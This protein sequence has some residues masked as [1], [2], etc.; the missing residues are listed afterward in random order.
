MELI[1]SLS[2]SVWTNSAEL[3]AV[4]RGVVIE[5]D[6]ASAE[7]W[8]LLM[9]RLIPA[10]EIKWV[11]SGHQVAQLVAGRVKGQGEECPL[12][13]LVVSDVIL[14]S[15][16]SGVDIWRQHKKYFGLYVIS[17]GLSIERYNRLFREGEVPPVYVPKPASLK[18]VVEIVEPL[19]RRY[20]MTRPTE[21]V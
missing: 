7:I 20:L 6:E 19:L 13:D 18:S 2:L 11:S 9:R 14:S 3:K 8:R 1:E 15:G 4:K 5:D 21:R 10:A 12:F 17:S 16:E